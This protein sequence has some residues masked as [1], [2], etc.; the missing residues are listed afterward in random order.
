VKL[1]DTAAQ[2]LKR[3]D[4]SVSISVIIDDLQRLFPG[5]EL[6]SDVMEFLGIACE[7]GW[8]VISSADS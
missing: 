6:S 5:A 2:I 3:V 1:S 7:R 4:G 8:I